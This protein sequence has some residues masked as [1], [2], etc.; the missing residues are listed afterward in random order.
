MLRRSVLW[1][2]GLSAVGCEGITRGGCKLEKR[3]SRALNGPAGQRTPTNAA[4]RLP[5]GLKGLMYRRSDGRSGS[6][7]R[8]ASRCL[9]PVS[10]QSSNSTQMNGRRN[11]CKEKRREEKRREERKASRP[12]A[13]CFFAR[14]AAEEEAAP[15]Q[16]PGVHC[17]GAF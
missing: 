11:A 17:G 7:Q 5:P 10:C 15:S 4:Q 3:C 8:G 6:E 14:K 9:T 2:R 16:V 1:T 12:P 13:V